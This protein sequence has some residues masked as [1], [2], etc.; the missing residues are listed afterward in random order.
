MDDGKI[1]LLEHRLRESLRT[2][3]E[4]DLKRKYS[5]LGII[6]IFLTSG[7]LVSLFNSVLNDTRVNLEVEKTLQQH[8]QKRY[9]E[10]EKKINKIVNEAFQQ[11]ANVSYELFLT[12]IGYLPII[13]KGLH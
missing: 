10:A 6:G 3:V 8:V 5:W 9:I 7:I 13:H 11:K 4:A 2:S 12:M 1:E